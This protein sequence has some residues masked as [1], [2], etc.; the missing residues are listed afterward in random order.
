MG[1]GSAL[2]LPGIE[3]NP[4]RRDRAMQEHSWSE[5]RLVSAGADPELPRQVC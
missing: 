4:G 1:P 5:P 3:L 2:A